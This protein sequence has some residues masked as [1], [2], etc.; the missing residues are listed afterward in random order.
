MT[1][2]LDKIK[3]F[4]LTDS[5]DTENLSTH[6]W[7]DWVRSSQVRLLDSSVPHN[8]LS[9]RVG[10]LGLGVARTGPARFSRKPPSWS[11]IQQTVPHGP[12][13]DL[14]L[15]AKTQLALDAVEAVP[16]GHRLDSPGLRNRAV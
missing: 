4:H 13:H 2:R 11:V 15:R 6:G 1:T 12:D 3:T 16:D 5:I 10:P 9:E 8:S 7:S 14:L